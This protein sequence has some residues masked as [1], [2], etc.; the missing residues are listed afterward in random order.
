MKATEEKSS[1]I[2]D[3]LGRTFKKLRIS[4]T[5]SCNFHCEYCVPEGE[6]HAR[7]KSL[8]PDE[9]ADIAL[10]INS[11]TPLDSIRITGGEPLLYK[12]V[13]KL[14]RLLKEGG[15]HKVSLTTNGSLLAGKMESLKEAGLDSVNISLDSL[16]EVISGKMS[17]SAR[18][19]DILHAVDVAIASGIK[20][21][22]N[23]T[24]VKDRNES[25][26]VPLLEYA[27]EKNIPLRY[28]ELMEMG[29]LKG[30]MPDKLLLAAD[31]LSLIKAKFSFHPAK[32]ETSSTADH[33]EIENSGG[34]QFGIISNISKPFCSD[35]DRLRL[36]SEGKI[37][38]CLSVNQG[39]DFQATDIN[40][41]LVNALHQKQTLKFTG[42]DLSMRSIGG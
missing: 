11:V 34:Y 12:G 6:S 31:I 3:S 13:S 17:R 38:G 15:I 41:I 22:L 42:S 40:S 26:I 35:C 5:S 14:V 29:H 10:K 28:I 16:D 24:A 9:L 2:T 1:R 19:S 18:F 23:C 7:V 32:R 25:Q 8:S 21:K 36:S 33:W 37:Y 4:V 30:H 39:F 27:M 20:V